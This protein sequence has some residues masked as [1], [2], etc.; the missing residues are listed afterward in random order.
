[1]VHGAFTTMTTVGVLGFS[2]VPI[3]S[4]TFCRLGIITVFV[5]LVNATVTFPAALCTFADTR[6]RLIRWWV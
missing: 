2:E 4:E 3:V 5:S 6:S 1:V